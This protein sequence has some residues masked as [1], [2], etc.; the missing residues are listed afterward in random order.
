MNK[1]TL[2]DVGHEYYS[3]LLKNDSSNNIDDYAYQVAYCMSHD[4]MKESPTW[5]DVQ[6]ACK[7]GA[8]WYKE[9]IQK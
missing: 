5:D 6:N 7:L 4:W 1:E 9:Q 8:L 2:T 3:E